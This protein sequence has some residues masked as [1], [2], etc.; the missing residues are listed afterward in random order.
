M[1]TVKA[2][3]FYRVPILFLAIII[4]II[5]TFPSI[6]KADDDER[7]TV[8]VGNISLVITN[9]G[10]MG[11]GFAERGRLSC[12]YPIGSHVEHMYM[13][14]L[15]V[16]GLKNNEIRVST[17]AIDVSRKPNGAASGFE[18]TTGYGVPGEIHTSPGD[19]IIERSLLP[20]SPY[21]DPN[22]ISHQDFI[23]TYTD[24]NS[25][26]PQTGEEIPDHRPLGL[27]SLRGATPGA[28]LSLTLMSF[29]I[30]R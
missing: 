28:N 14:G 17:G 23:C 12:E 24:S 15:W 9:Y 1:K 8:N 25:V 22:A 27:L 6:L 30:L 16:G 21:Y 26:I 2:A 10:T 11:L 19:S 13:G 18:F 5:I 7:H 20:V 3:I 4:S 29:L